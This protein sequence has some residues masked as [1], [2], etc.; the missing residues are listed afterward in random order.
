MKNLAAIVILTAMC[1]PAENCMSQTQEDSS[2]STG[3]DVVQAELISFGEQG[4]RVRSAA[5]DEEFFPLDDLQAYRLKDGRLQVKHVSGRVIAL[6]SEALGD[7]AVLQDGEWRMLSLRGVDARYVDVDV[8]DRY[9]ETVHLRSRD[10]EHE[11]QIDELAAYRVKD[12]KIQ[13]K[14]ESGIVLVISQEIAAKRS[15]ASGEWRNISGK[16]SAHREAL[17]PGSRRKRGAVSSMEAELE[18]A[19]GD[20]PVGL[21]ALGIACLVVDIAFMICFGLVICTM[22]LNGEIT[23]GLICVALTCVIGCGPMVG[24]YY[25][26]SNCQAWRIQKLMIAWSVLWVIGIALNII[27]WTTLPDLLMQMDPRFAVRGA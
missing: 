6:P 26:W 13:V 14:H 23:T 7:S 24:L 17:F 27:L 21:V 22:F 9:K 5:G 8:V 11:Y 2:H 18:K 1:L 16:N 15:P 19:L 25:G 10:G 3:A 20:I 12:G 4:L